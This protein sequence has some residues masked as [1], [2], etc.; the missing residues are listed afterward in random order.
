MSVTVAPVVQSVT[1]A[2]VVQSLTVS[3][4]A[5]NN[6]A[7]SYY[8]TIDTD[9]ALSSVNTAQNVFAVPDDTFTLTADSVWLFEGSY[10][11]GS[12]AVSHSTTLGFLEAGNG[13][14]HF[15]TFAT[16]VGAYSTPTRTQDMT[17]FN[18][19]TG[20]AVNA[21]STSPLTVIT[22]SGRISVVSATNFIPFIT[23]SAAPTGTN[24]VKTGSWLRLTGLWT[25]ATKTADDQWT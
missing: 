4:V 10:V 21:T 1:V 25:G 15:T 8:N 2:P 11:I 13:S 5:T 7:Q 12:G 3:S 19:S 22:F 18:S 9:R 14:C 16:G 6:G 23:F 24:A 17:A 20:G